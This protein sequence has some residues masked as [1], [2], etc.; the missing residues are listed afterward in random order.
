MANVESIRKSLQELM[1]G[2]AVMGAN[3]PEH[4][5]NE[6]AKRGREDGRGLIRTSRASSPEG[7]AD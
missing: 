7:E 6:E 4:S 1:D 2:L 5:E 3:L